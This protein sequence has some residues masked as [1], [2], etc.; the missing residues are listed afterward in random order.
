MFSKIALICL[1]V[2]TL[3]FAHSG[4]N[5]GYAHGGIGFQFD[6][7]VPD[8]HGPVDL[9]LG[10]GFMGIV[11]FSLGRAGELH[12]TPNVD[13]WF[14][15][16]HFDH[17]HSIYQ[18]H[19]DYTAGEI[20]INFADLRYYF[21]VPIG[22]K[23]FVGLGPMMALEYQ[24]Q[25]HHYWMGPASTGYWVE[26]ENYHDWD[27]NVGFNLFGGIDFKPSDDFAIGF[28]AKGKLGDWDVFKM[29]VELQ[30]LF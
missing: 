24:K 13:A 18:E 14:G 29:I 28:I 20:G 8:D 23:P 15:G 25:E 22:V 5:V 10:G 19:Y 16:D 27:P 1:A 30:F 2:V 26:D 6:L 7:V 3:L 21:P 9:G 17:D 11:A 4:G 12:Y